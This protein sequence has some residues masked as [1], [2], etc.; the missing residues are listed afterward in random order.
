MG[1]KG[2]LS[3]GLCNAAVRSLAA[4]IAASEEEVAGVL[5]KCGKFDCSGNM[6]GAGFCY[7]Y[8]MASVMLGIIPDVPSIHP[9][10]RPYS[11][12]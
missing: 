4:S 1:A 2:V 10:D 7:I 9:M 5:Y 8:F 3:W 6:F 11:S 12:I